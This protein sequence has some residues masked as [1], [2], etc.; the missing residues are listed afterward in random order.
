MARKDRDDSNSPTHPVKPGVT[1]FPVLPEPQSDEGCL[2]YQDWLVV[3]S[4]LVCDVS[5]SAASGGPECLRQWI[6]PTR[7]GFR[8][9]L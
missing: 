3:V 7:F 9:P 8:H 1:S 5:D 4:G 2:L 6:M